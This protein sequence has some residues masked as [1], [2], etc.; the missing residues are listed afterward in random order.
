MYANATLELEHRDNALS[1]P[2]QAV[3]QGTNEHYVLMV[4][5]QGHVQK[6]PVALGEQ[7]SNRVEILSGLAD[8]DQVIVGGQSNYQIGE[9][10][11]PRIE[12]N[13]AQHGQTGGQP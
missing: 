11:K 12:Q 10:V 7:T 3:I 1:V 2:V 8:R 6:R 4:D 9:L 5:G 13:R